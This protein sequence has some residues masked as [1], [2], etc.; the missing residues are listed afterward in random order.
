MLAL[1]MDR[2]AW[3]RLAEFVGAANQ[4][5]LV[6]AKAEDAGKQ[7]LTM[8]DDSIKEFLTVDVPPDFWLRL[9]SLLNE[10]LRNGDEE[11][12]YV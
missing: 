5:R 12:T 1:E 9:G 3:E 2:E 10:K 11:Q 8:R 4:V 7:Q 6:M